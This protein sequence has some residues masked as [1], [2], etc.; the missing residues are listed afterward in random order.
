MQ[1]T[2]TKIFLKEFSA[3]IFENVVWGWNILAY[4]A[5]KINILACMYALSLIL[6]WFYRSCDRYMTQDT[7]PQSRF[8]S[9]CKNKATDNFQSSL[10]DPNIHRAAIND[11]FVCY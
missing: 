5:I 3:K 9:V 2:A 11:L 7:K 8:G 1:Q 10:M 4:H 6:S